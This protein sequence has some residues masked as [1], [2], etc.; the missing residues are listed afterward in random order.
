MHRILTAVQTQ[1]PGRV[2]GTLQ[3]VVLLLPITLSV[4][5]IVVLIPVLPQILAEFS[6][7]PHYEYLVQGGVLTMPALCIAIFSPFAGWLA[8]RVGRRGLLMSAMLVHAVVGVAPIFLHDL[9]AIIA[10]RVVVGISEAVVMTASTTLIGDYFK[11]HDRERWLANQT[12][13]ASLSAVFLI[14]IAGWLGSAF[15]WRGPFTVYA[16]SAVLMLGVWWFTWEPEDEAGET[17]D[18]IPAE[19]RHPFPW[20]RMIGICAITLCASI[21]FYT[22]QTQNGIALDE[23][24]VTDASRIGLYTSLASLGV[25]LGTF[26]FRGAS[27]RLPVG[28]LLAV[29]FLVIGLGFVGM[30]KSS[31]TAPYLVA[32]A[33]N[34]IGCGMILPTLLTWAVRGLAFEIR[35]RGTG[36]WQGTFSVGQFLSGIVVTFFGKQ[37]GG[38]F[39][40]LMLLGAGG[41]A[42]AVLCLVGHWY[43]RGRRSTEQRLAV[44]G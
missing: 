3:G 36:L 28:L 42:I 22:V 24:G 35:G 40:A 39:P 30:A 41:V 43:T 17:V 2:P 15:G 23:L 32:A 8:D 34:Q 14:L 5:G 19:A 29:E 16:S 13:L 44:G 31:Q 12:A 10:S 7:V 25:P 26:I 33:V 38:L 20:A 27:T 18:H 37:V 11:G 21:M 9:Y 1:N 6:T 4:M